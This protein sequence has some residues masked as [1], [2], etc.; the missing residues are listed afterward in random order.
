M[1]VT[2]PN[3]ATPITNPTTV[4]C[5]ADFE[6][7]V[8]RL[9]NGPVRIVFEAWSRPEL[10]QRWWAPK[11]LG[12][13]LLSCEMDVRTGGSYRL[14]FGKDVSQSF[15]FFGKYVEVIPQSR[16]VWTN[17][18]E[19]GGAVTTVTFEAKGDKTLL[20]LSEVYPTKEARDLAVEGS[21]AGLPE[22]FGQLDALLLELG[23]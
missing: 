14:V 6:L 10:F 4:E 7:V 15:A 23:A 1:S 9:F 18:E 16:I 2:T 13:P 12:I 8:T 17:E 21:A 5:K 20:T 22:Q 19:E 3:E 11:S